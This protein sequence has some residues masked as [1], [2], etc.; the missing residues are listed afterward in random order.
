VATVQDVVLNNCSLGDACIPIAIPLSVMTGY[1]LCAVNI[2]HTSGEPALP[3]KALMPVVAV[4][5][6]VTFLRAPAVGVQVVPDIRVVGAL[7]ALLAGCAI[8]IR[9]TKRTRSELSRSLNVVRVE[10]RDF[11]S[12]FY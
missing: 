10:F 7:Q 5:A 9:G 12:G 2:Y 11:I 8:T 1:G 3:Q 6:A 4:A